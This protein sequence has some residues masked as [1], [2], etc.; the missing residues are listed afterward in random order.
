MGSITTLCLSVK[1]SGG[2]RGPGPSATAFKQA[3]EK[4]YA[5]LPCEPHSVIELYRCAACVL[6]D[7]ST[8]VAGRAEARIRRWR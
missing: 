6:A 8:L 4:R 7:V 2:Y 5:V 3:L 1:L